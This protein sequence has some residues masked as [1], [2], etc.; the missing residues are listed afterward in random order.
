MSLDVDAFGTVLRAA[1]VT[2]PRR[3]PKIPEQAESAVI[4]TERDVVHDTEDA[5]RLHVALPIEARSWEL[6]GLAVPGGRPFTAAEI[7]AA[8]SA[9]GTIPPEDEPTGLASQQQ[10]HRPASATCTTTISPGRS[11]PD[12]PD[13][14]RSPTGPSGSLSHRASSMR[15]SAT[16]LMPPVLEGDGGYTSDDGAWWAPSGRAVLDADAFF[17]PVGTVDERGAEAVTEYDDYHLLPIRTTDPAGNSFSAVNHY[18][19]LAP[20]SI[21]DSN[22][23]RRSVRFDALG[24]VVAIADMGK[25]GRNEG[26]ST[27]SHEHRARARRRPDQPDRVPDGEWANRGRPSSVRTLARDR[28]RV[29]DARWHESYAY[30]DGTGEEVLTKSQAEPGRRPFATARASWSTVPMGPSSSRT[31]PNAGWAAGGPSTTRAAGPS[32]ATNRSSRAR[33]SSRTRP[34][35]SA[36]G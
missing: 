24:R 13:R 31:S 11:R 32:G 10:G 18:R 22:G 35:S 27:R 2:Y 4:V 9:A 23:N 28:H 20:W 15:C 8:F 19:V 1:S 6:A 33:S 14:A 5:A 3:A 7:A 16:S 36:S 30:L 12:R 17:L 34:I 25:D 26:D 21:V 29:A